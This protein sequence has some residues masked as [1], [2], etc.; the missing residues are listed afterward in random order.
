MSLSK[1]ESELIKQ[2]KSLS[3]SIFGNSKNMEKY[4]KQFNR[5]ITEDDFTLEMSS[6]N[7]EN[8]NFTLHYPR[9][10][11]Y[12]SGKEEFE[13]GLRN[14]S[15]FFRISENEKNTVVRHLNS[16]ARN[17]EKSIYSVMSEIIENNKESYNLLLR[18]ER[19][20]NDVLDK[21]KAKEQD[22]GLER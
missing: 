12:F 15:K 5:N 6:L 2:M 20:I 10:D 14:I 19:N 9:A 7:K 8:G 13:Q 22:K 21:E 11:F 3:N 4:L 17:R 1:Y 16:I 18:L